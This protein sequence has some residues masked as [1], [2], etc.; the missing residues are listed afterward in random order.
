[1]SQTAVKVKQRHAHHRTPLQYLLNGV[2]D[3][4]QNP[5]DLAVWKEDFKPNKMHTPPVW[6][7]ECFQAVAG[8]DVSADDR[9]DRAQIVHS[10]VLLM[11]YGDL[12]NRLRKNYLANIFTYDETLG[13]LFLGLLT[14]WYLADGAEIKYFPSRT[15]DSAYPNKPVKDYPRASISAIGAMSHLADFFDFRYDPEYF[16]PIKNF[17]AKHVATYNNTKPVALQ[18][19]QAIVPALT[20]VYDI[21]VNS[22]GYCKETEI[23][24]INNITSPTPEQKTGKTAVLGTDFWLKYYDYVTVMIA[25]TQ[26][27]NITGTTRSSMLFNTTSGTLFYLANLGTFGL[28]EGTFFKPPTPWLGQPARILAHE[29]FDNA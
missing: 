11:V 28:P 15:I 26:M 10:I 16:T 27:A 4:I 1:M 23:T 8:L 3:E 9:I 29:V 20:S 5:S 22:I 6:V 14:G 24:F 21:V 18:A 2:V 13:D 7:D 25:Q 12:Y 19:K 17:A